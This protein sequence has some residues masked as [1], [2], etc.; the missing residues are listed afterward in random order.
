MISDNLVDILENMAELCKKS[1]ILKDTKGG[2]IDKDKDKNPEL[3]IEDLEGEE[4]GDESDD[5]SFDA[6]E[7]DEVNEGET[8]VSPIL[9]I[10]D[11]NYFRQALE[12]LGQDK[13]NQ[14]IQ[15]LNDT[16]REDLM[17]AFEFCKE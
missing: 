8:Y 13:M 10:N 1:V 14:L 17:K 4:W 6:G 11:V 3:V 15:G 16:A 9:E 7:D 5:D 12:S 2:A